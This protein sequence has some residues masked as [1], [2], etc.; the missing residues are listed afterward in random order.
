VLPKK[1]FFGQYTFFTGVT[2]AHVNHLFE[3]NDFTVCHTID[4]GRFKELMKESTPILETYFSLR[5][6]VLFENHL[7]R[8]KTQCFFCDSEEHVV[9]RCPRLRLTVDAV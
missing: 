1:T 8:I 9:D 3:A 4:C 6:K 5:N 2:H 7:K